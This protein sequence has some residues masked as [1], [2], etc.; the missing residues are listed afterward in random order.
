MRFFFLPDLE[1]GNFLF[2]EGV[3]AG[4][5]DVDG[6]VNFE[7]VRG[8]E[9]FSGFFLGVIGEDGMEK[10]EIFQEGH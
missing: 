6:V 8:E 4:A 5:N 10:F 3:G 7:V 2:K 9:D 1:G